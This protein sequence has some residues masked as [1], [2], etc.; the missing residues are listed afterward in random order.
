MNI[1]N[2]IDKRLKQELNK[3]YTGSLIELENKAYSIKRK[4]KTMKEVAQQRQKKL[5]SHIV[6]KTGQH[7]NTSLINLAKELKPGFFDNK[8][9]NINTLVQYYSKKFNGT[10]IEKY[11]VDNIKKLRINSTKFDSTSM[12]NYLYNDITSRSINIDRAICQKYNVHCIEHI[13]NGLSEG[14][15]I[16]KSFNYELW[17][18]N[19]YIGYTE[20]YAMLYSTINRT[21]YTT[22]EINDMLMHNNNYLILVTITSKNRLSYKEYDKGMAILKTK[23]TIENFSV[24]K[25]QI[26]SME[27]Y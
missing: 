14:T 26:D 18:T 8:H 3:T 19:Y 10:I 5:N 25:K 12:W 13:K 15:F 1:L 17:T 7:L 6:E 27:F 16:S 23:L 24:A 2:R 21:E 9:I 4:Y 20:A 11:V 22:K